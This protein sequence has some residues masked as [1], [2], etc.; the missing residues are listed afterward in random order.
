MDLVTVRKGYNY[1]TASWEEAFYNLNDS[2]S[3]N[4]VVKFPKGAGPWAPGG[5]FVSHNAVRINCVQDV[6]KDL[7]C[8]T[9]H[10]YIGIDITNSG[11]GKHADKVDVWIWQNKGVTRWEYQNPLD[12]EKSSTLNEGDLIYIPKGIYHKANSVTARFSITMFKETEEELTRL[13]KRSI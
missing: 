4:E 13:N 7:G 2:I 12:V 3:K 5:F 1:N 6:L 10:L 9:A 8:Q 11:F